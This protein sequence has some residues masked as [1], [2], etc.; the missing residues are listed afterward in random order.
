MGLINIVNFFKGKGLIQSKT[1]E[2]ILGLND[3]SNTFHLNKKRNTE[4]TNEKVNEAIELLI[5]TIKHAP[6]SL[7]KKNGDCG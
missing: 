6:S 4:C 3:M 1:A 2:S 7:K 5:H